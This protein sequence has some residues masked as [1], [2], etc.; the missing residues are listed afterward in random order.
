MLT[1]ELFYLETQRLILRIIAF[2]TYIAAVQEIML[3]FF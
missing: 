3:F 1:S 2:I